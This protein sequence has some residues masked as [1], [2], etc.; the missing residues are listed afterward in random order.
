MK[1][2]MI[3]HRV[4]DLIKYFW[5]YGY[6]T[7]SRKFG[8]YLP[9]PKMVGDY[10][11]DAIG[12]QKKKYAIGIIL[13]PEELNDPKIFSKLNFLATRNTKYSNNRVTLFLGIP[14]DLINKAKLIITELSEEARKNIKLVTIT[15]ERFQKFSAG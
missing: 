6:L 9:E 12:K 11:V 1:N 4:D 14:S 2:S 3:Q 8:T 10:Q 15:Q 7:I 13:T 5:K